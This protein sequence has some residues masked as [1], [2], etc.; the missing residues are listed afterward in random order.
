MPYSPHVVNGV[1]V[2]PTY[3]NE[4]FGEEYADN[5]NDSPSESSDSVDDSSDISDSVDDS[6]DEP[7]IDNS[8]MQ[9][10]FDF[11]VQSGDAEFVRLMIGSVS[12]QIHDNTALK[13]ALMLDHQEI[14][15]ILLDDPRVV[16]VLQN[17]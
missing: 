10:F 6:Y 12:P 17:Q 3:Q 11:A 15:D 13:M 16:D 1:P 14:V 8:N 9:L 7:E 4:L 2:A 5:V